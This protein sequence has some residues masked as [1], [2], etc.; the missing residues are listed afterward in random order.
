MT[1]TTIDVM[2]GKIDT[3]ELLFT[4]NMEDDRTNCYVA[5][6]DYDW[7]MYTFKTSFKTLK[8]GL[9]QIYIEFAGS[10]WS[11]MDVTQKKDTAMRILRYRF[12]TEIF[13]KHIKSY[14][15][16]HIANWDNLYAFDPEDEIVDFYNDIIENHQEVTTIESRVLSENEQKVL[17]N[18][19][20]KCQTNPE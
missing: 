19:F 8:Y 16:K 14:L 11:Y 15:K 6:D 20:E 3:A 2:P 10:N 4:G 7:M 17:K 12:N 5:L 18:T 9:L 1:K 13:K